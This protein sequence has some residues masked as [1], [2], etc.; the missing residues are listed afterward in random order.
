M[1]SEFVCKVTENKLKTETYQL[2]NSQTQKLAIQNDVSLMNFPLSLRVHR[3]NNILNTLFEIFR[4]RCFKYYAHGGHIEDV[5][6]KKKK[7]S[8]DSD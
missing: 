6:I 4:W 7:F 2:K 5:A 3:A 1:R 8:S